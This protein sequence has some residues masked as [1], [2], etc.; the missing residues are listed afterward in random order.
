[1]K[2]LS[3]AQPKNSPRLGLGGDLAD[4]SVPSRGQHAPI[5]TARDQVASGLVAK[6]F[7]GLL[8]AAVLAGPLALVTVV[9]VW[10]TQPN[11]VEAV[12]PTE[13]PGEW[14]R[15]QALA[16]ET[17]M[18]VV[19]AWMSATRDQPGEYLTLV[20]GS[21]LA[22]LPQEPQQ[23]RDLAIADVRRDGQLWTVT[24]GLTVLPGSNEPRVPATDDSDT[25]S[26]S[27]NEPANP[28]APEAALESVR[29][30][31]EV[32]VIVD[33]ETE[34]AAAAAAPGLVAAPQITEPVALDY[35]ESMPST[36]APVQTVTRFFEAYL[37]GA[38]E[39]ARYT[40]PQASIRPVTPPPYESLTILEARPQERMDDLENPDDGQHLEVLVTARGT[41]GTQPSPPQ[42]WALT[43]TAR[44]G[45]WEV[46]TLG[47]P[48]MKTPGDQPD[49]PGSPEPG[50]PSL[51]PTPGATP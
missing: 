18:R 42:T 2:L 44:G 12:A 14:A 47:S 3:R 49:A 36:S 17:G 22:T 46:E 32:P 28:T 25:T 45:R 8:W 15:A 16:E 1:M 38:G 41:V 35:R 5:A 19:T 9:A 51:T 39:V 40:A 31:F 43:L 10:M 27:T 7:N 37:T 24:V 4:A 50:A 6:V 30:Y 48:H 21:R 29:R 23:W 26:E 33:L 13:E 20:P 11:G 34:L